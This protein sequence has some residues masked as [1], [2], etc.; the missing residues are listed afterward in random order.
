LFSALRRLAFPQH[1]AQLGANSERWI[2]RAARV[3]RHV[4]N[5][6]SAQA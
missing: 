3:L 1:F 4:G 2:Q 5:P 6:I